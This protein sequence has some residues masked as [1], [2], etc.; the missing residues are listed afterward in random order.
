MQTFFNIFA[1]VLQKAFCNHWQVRYQVHHPYPLS[2]PFVLAS[3][4]AVLILYCYGGCCSIGDAEN[5]YTSHTQTE[6]SFAD[7]GNA[8]WLEAPTLNWTQAS[9]LGLMR[10]LQIAACESLL[11]TYFMQVLRSDMSLCL[12]CC[13][14]MFLNVYLA[15]TAVHL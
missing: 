3:A 10:S 13:L 7:S 4:Q 14:C 15:G 1:G 6:A 12:S 5:I 11:E 8:R 2:I 9:S